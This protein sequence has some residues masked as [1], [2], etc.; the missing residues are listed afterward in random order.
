M[1]L[2]YNISWSWTTEHWPLPEVAIPRQCRLTCV[3]SWHSTLVDTCKR[4]SSIVTSKVMSPQRL[5]IRRLAMVVV[6]VV[7][8]WC[9]TLVNL[10]GLTKTCSLQSSVS[11]WLGDL[12]KTSQNIFILIKKKFPN[13]KILVRSLRDDKLIEKHTSLGSIDSFQEKGGL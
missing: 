11:L 12:K 9:P 1:E 6:C 5:C 13:K 7:R 10:L 3:D 4:R 8:G 2:D